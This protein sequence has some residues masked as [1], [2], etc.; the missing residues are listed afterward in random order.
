MLMRVP[1]FVRFFTVLKILRNCEPC[2]CLIYYYN[3]SLESNIHLKLFS[4]ANDRHHRA[5]RQ[6]RT[7]SHFVRY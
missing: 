6:P 5:I 1:L 2:V 7:Q 3:D 4:V